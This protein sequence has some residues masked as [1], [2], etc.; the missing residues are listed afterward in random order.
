LNGDKIKLTGFL[1]GNGATNW[2]YDVSP[3]FPDTSFN[4]NIIPQHLL[5]FMQDNGCVYYFNGSHDGPE[6]CDAVWNQI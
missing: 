5:Q 1:V 4:F 6:T 2:T 3:S